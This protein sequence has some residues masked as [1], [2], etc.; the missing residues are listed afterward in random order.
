MRDAE[1]KLIAS[2]FIIISF[3]RSP[4]SERRCPT[5]LIN[6][7][8]M[9]IEAAGERTEQEARQMEFFPNKIT[10]ALSQIIKKKKKNWDGGNILS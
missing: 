8:L 3:V 10:Y 6:T 5:L 7:H 9:L 1:G 2:T 4:F